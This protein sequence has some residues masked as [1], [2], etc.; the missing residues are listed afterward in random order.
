MGQ[1]LSSYSSLQSLTAIHRS[2]VSDQSLQESK[3]LAMAGPTGPVLNLLGGAEVVTGLHHSWISTAHFCFPS[4]P[5]TGTDAAFPT[6]ATQVPS[7]RAGT[8]GDENS[9]PVRALPF[10]LLSSEVFK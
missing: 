5:P 4:L 3:G 6:C 7:Q 9:S 1:P 10:L 2:T 8:G